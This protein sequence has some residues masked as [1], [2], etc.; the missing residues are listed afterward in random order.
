M[1]MHP[2][3]RDEIFEA[4]SDLPPEQL[5]E[6]RAFIEFLRFKSEKRPR[7]LI[8]LGGLWKDLPPITEEDIAEARREMWGE[9]GEREI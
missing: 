8:Q 6:L 2:V 9:F 3:T 4:V 1:A 5:P 7:N